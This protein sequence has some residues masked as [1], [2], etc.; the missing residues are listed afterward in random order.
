VVQR[1]MIRA[2]F[3][4]IDIRG[5]IPVQIRGVARIGDGIQLAANPMRLVAAPMPVNARLKPAF[6]ILKRATE[7]RAFPGGVL[8]V[9]HRGELVLHP[10]GKLTYDKN[11]AE[12]ESETI[13]DVASLTKPIVTTSAVMLLAAEGL[14]DIRAPISRYLSDWGKGPNGELREKAT[15]RDLLLHTSGLPAHREFYKTAK[16]TPD[17]LKRVCAEPLTAEPGARIEYSDL[18]FMLLG[19]IVER[20]TGKGLDQFARGRIFAPLEMKHSCFDPP[21]NLRMQTAPTQNDTA[22][23]KRQFRGEVD[24][25]NAF[26]MGG[27]AGH[28]GLFSTAEDLSIFAQMM[29]NGG[30]YAHLRIFPRGIVNEFTARV[31]VGN[32]ARALGWDVPTENS[33]SGRYFSQQSYGHNGFTGTSIWIDPKKGLFVILLTNRVHPFAAND[34]IREVR[35]ALHNAV[36]EGLELA[37]ERN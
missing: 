5:K 6:D 3:G 19:E 4:Q 28:A 13:Y 24:D 34:K 33:S 15:V 20:L 9:G 18:G 36:V 35:P 12:A 2:L 22:F 26:A 25:A 16:N 37:T 17:V 10:F 1:A 7:E 8:A 27:V 30:V 31:N 29:L 11:A 32:S 23:R 14:L 21:R